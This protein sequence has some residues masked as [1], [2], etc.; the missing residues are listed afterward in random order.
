M[1]VFEEDGI[2]KSFKIILNTRGVILKTKTLWATSYKEVYSRLYHE[3]R[4]IKL[5]SKIVQTEFI[6]D[7]NVL[8]F[9]DSDEA[10]IING[11]I[12]LGKTNIERLIYYIGEDTCEVDIDEIDLEE[13]EGDVYS[14]RFNRSYSRPSSSEPIG[15]ADSSRVGMS[16]SATLDHIIAMRMKAMGVGQQ[17]QQSAPQ[18]AQAAPIV[19][20]P[21]GPP[22]I[23]GGCFSFYAFIEG[24]QQGPYDEK[25]FGNLVQY[26]LVNANT[27]VWKEGMA[28][29]QNANT[30][31]ETMKFFQQGNGMTPPPPPIG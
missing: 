24:K 12:S 8:Y 16:A 11:L 14:N 28:Q 20:T 4:S 26:G 2:K 17:S 5:T 15:S 25:Q 21:A 31:P 23:G 7:D 29:W 18:Q 10:E 27:P 1:L 9:D 6:I 30:V 13:V 22:P 3:V 19:Q